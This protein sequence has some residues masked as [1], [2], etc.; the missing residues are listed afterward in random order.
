[1]G[2]VLVGVISQFSLLIDDLISHTAA[3]CEG[4]G[5]KIILYLHNQSRRCK[6]GASSL[7]QLVCV[8]VCVCVCRSVCFKS[9]MAEMVDFFK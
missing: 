6:G 2:V 7:L 9:D 8:S 1:M 5:H 4:T 3:N